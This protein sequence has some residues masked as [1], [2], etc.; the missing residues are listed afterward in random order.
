MGMYNEVFCECPKCGGFGYLQVPQFV[1]GFGGFYL[2][3]PET[4]LELS[5]EDLLKLKSI[6]GKERFECEKCGNYFL[7]RPN[8]TDK[9]EFIEKLFR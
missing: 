4:M 8:F 9:L 5:Y 3:R 6:L 7:Y 1:L 2:D